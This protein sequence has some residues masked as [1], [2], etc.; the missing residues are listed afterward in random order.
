MQES[1]ER[2]L[3]RNDKTR[4][5]ECNEDEHEEIDEH[6]DEGIQGAYRFVVTLVRQRMAATGKSPATSLYMPRPPPVVVNVLV[7]VLPARRPSLSQGRVRE[8]DLPHWLRP[9]REG[10]PKRVGYSIFV[11][12]VFG[13]P[14]VIPE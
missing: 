10:F 11:N 9:R 4:E 5:G 13:N 14:S 1:C 2:E 6:R 8:S 7:V 3:G 12:R